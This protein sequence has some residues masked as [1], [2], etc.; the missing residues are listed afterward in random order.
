V[1]AETES[2]DASLARNLGY[3]SRVAETGLP[4][5][6]FWGI[7]PHTILAGDLLAAC[8]G[9]ANGPVTQWLMMAESH[10]REDA[11]PLLLG[12][13]RTLPLNGPLVA[14]RLLTHDAS[15]VRQCRW[16]FSVL[17]CAACPLAAR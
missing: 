14:L 16:R 4:T 7:A 10:K 11:H 2:H 6:Q 13:L 1:R 8:A 15:E 12:L 3:G 5:A 17:L 9:S